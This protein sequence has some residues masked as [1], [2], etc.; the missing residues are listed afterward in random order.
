MLN[1][2]KLKKQKL[3]TSFNLQFTNYNLT[4]PIKKGIK[5]VLSK[6]NI[7]FYND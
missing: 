1:L 3:A 7:K 5:Y 2:Y 6:K 4:R